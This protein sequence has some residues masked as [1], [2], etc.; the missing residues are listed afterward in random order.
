MKTELHTLHIDKIRTMDFSWMKEAMPERWNKAHRFLKEED[1]L[2]C[3]GAGILLRDFAG[4]KSEKEISFNGYEKPFSPGKKYFN[5]SHSAEICAIAVSDEE[6]G[7]DVEKLEAVFPDEAKT[8]FTEEEKI[9][10]GDSSERAYE[11]WTMKESV[12]KA[13]GMGFSFEP[14]SFSVMPCLLGEVLKVKDCFWEIER[15]KKD[16]YVFS[17]CSKAGQGHGGRGAFTAVEQ[18]GT[19]GNGA[20]RRNP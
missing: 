12:M 5:L 9:W 16:G 7:L 4:I 11:I 10:A 14:E 3:L 13:I 15:M 6:V 8:V 2:L 20:L 1:R 17:V 19:D 18:G